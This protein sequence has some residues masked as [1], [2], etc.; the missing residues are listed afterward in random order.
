MFEPSWNKHNTTT[1]VNINNNKHQENKQ[2]A[3]F[4]T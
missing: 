4:K 3:L 2:S 1:E